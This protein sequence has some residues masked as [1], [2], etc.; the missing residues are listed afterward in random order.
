MK[1]YSLL[2]ALHAI[3]AVKA[4]IVHFFYALATYFLIKVCGKPFQPPIHS[5]H[6]IL[7]NGL[8]LI[9]PSCNKDIRK[10]TKA[11]PSWVAFHLTI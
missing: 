5:F 3:L 7:K 9:V 11:T 2:L 1:Q 8:F 6:A 4:R 10:Y